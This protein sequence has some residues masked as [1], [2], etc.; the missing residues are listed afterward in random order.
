MYS[1]FH[2]LDANERLPRELVLEGKRHRLMELRHL[3]IA[4]ALYLPALIFAIVLMGSV[5][6]SVL[7]AFAIAGLVFTGF[8]VYVVAARS[9]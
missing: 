5:Q 4:A 1:I 9:R 2:P 8:L 6:V 7:A 3:E